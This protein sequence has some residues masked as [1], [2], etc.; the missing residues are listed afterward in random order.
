MDMEIFLFIGL[1]ATL[2]LVFQT[3]TQIFMD[4]HILVITVC[5]LTMELV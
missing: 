3:P 1:Q 5:M 4:F 2:I